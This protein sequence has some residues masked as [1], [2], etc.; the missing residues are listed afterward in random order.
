MYLCSLV[1]KVFKYH[2]MDISAWLYYSAIVYYIYEVLSTLTIAAYRIM[3]GID[4]PYP[5]PRVYFSDLQCFGG[6]Q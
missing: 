2:I 5:K 4:V 3:D 1:G 6:D